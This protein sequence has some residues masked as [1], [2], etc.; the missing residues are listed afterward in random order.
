MRG[1][2]QEEE[3][4]YSSED[5]T[6]TCNSRTVAQAGVAFKTVTVSLILRFTSTASVILSG[7]TCT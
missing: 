5:G 6:D 1:S 3:R 2:H 4:R 7:V